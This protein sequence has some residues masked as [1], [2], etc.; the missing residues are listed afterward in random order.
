MLFADM[1]VGCM[2]FADMHVGCMLLA[3]SSSSTATHACM[4]PS[5]QQRPSH[6][7]PLTKG[8]GDVRLVHAPVR[9]LHAALQR[10]G[11]CPGAATHQLHLCCGLAPAQRVQVGP[12]P[13][14]GALLAGHV[15]H[16]APDA[17]GAVRRGPVV[18]HH[19]C[20][21]LLGG[22]PQVVGQL[23]WAG[24]GEVGATT[25]VGVGVGM[26]RSRPA[27]GQWVQSCGVRFAWHLHGAPVLQ[28]TAL[29]S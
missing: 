13:H 21:G 4:R 26:R 25:G 1:H 23:R 24:A 19:H 8:G 18:V 7:Y 28:H 14:E 17:G 5:S 10:H 6:P 9:H 3:D 12:Q 15:L 11:G 16:H 20:R 29:Q 27:A 22:V 2:L